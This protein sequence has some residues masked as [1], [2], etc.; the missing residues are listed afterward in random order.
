MHPDGYC[1]KV[2]PRYTLVPPSSVA[3]PAL[4]GTADQKNSARRTAVKLCCGS[5]DA[6][7]INHM[8]VH[9]DA[10]GYTFGGSTAW[11]ETPAKKPQE[12]CQ[13]FVTAMGTCT[14]STSTGAWICCKP[15]RL[16]TSATPAPPY[17][18]RQA[19]LSGPQA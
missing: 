18:P 5:V 12:G 1:I 3:E 2:A 4:V 8:H 16:L 11:Q 6:Q 9:Y 7:L 14:A 19:L 17:P 15:A 10:R 13:H